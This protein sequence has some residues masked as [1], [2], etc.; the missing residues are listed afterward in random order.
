MQDNPSAIVIT[1]SIGKKTVHRAVA[2]VLNQTYA[3]VI[4]LIVVYGPEYFAKAQSAL[5]DL[6][7][8]PRVQVLSLPQNTGKNGYV[9]HRIYGAMP[10]LVNQDYIFYLDD[11]NWYDNDH[12]SDHVLLCEREDLKWSYGLRKIISEDGAMICRDDCESLGCW[13]TWYNPQVHHVDTNCYCLTRKA[14][15]ELASR[16]HRSRLK[17]GE[18]QPSADTE[19]CKFLLQRYPKCGIVG[20]YSV[21][22]VLGSWGLSPSPDFFLK[23]NEF[24]ISRYGDKL[25]WRQA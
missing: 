14:A 2:S 4:S 10:L 25:P 24:T 6:A 19:I 1:A 11:D 16:W 17:S 18:V 20:K 15:I 7:N 5:G 8:D 9:C 12:V 3:N 13:P 22:Y 21:N 23:G